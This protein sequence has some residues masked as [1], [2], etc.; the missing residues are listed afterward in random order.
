LAS[1]VKLHAL[2][3]GVIAMGDSHRVEFY[4][5]AEAALSGLSSERV[6][7]RHFFTEVAPCTNNIMVAHRYESEPTLDATIGYV[8]TLRMRPTPVTLRLLQRDGAA[9]QFLLVQRG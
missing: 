4:N 3:F 7:G 5:V 9:R 8:F 1:D 2:E 6:L